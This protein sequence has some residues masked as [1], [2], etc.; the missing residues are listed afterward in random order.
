MEVACKHRVPRFE[1]A[2]PVRRDGVG[3]VALLGVDEVGQNIAAVMVGFLE[4][5]DGEETSGPQTAA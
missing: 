3:E 2:V 1:H 4:V 5:G